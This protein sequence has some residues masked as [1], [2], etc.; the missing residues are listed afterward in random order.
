MLGYR[1]S[2]FVMGM[3]YSRDGA[4]ASLLVLEK[5]IKE[6]ATGRF[7]PDHTRS[8][9]IHVVEHENRTFE[10]PSDVPLVVVKDEEPAGAA[11]VVDSSVELDVR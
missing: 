10:N 9:R 4:A 11:E 5:L 8:G 7:E 1:T 6:I 2:K 3:T